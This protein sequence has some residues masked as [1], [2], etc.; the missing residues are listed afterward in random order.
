MHTLVRTRVPSRRCSSRGDSPRAAWTMIAGAS[1]TGRSA[2]SPTAVADPRQHASATAA[3]AA[4]A[5]D[6]VYIPPV[7]V[8]LAPVHLDTLCIEPARLSQP[9]ACCVSHTGIP[10]P[11]CALRPRFRLHDVIPF[12]NLRPRHR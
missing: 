12:R 8:G 7:Q 5:A 4:A 3:A 11:R 1:D 6:V 2:V 10:P 9:A